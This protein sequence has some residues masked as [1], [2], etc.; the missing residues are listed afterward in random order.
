MSKLK[1]LFLVNG[2]ACF[3][4]AGFLTYGLRYVDVNINWYVGYMF[5]A[6]LGGVVN[7]Y[8]GLRST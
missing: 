2:L 3:V 1:T 4:V 8:F 7:L 5:F 6:Y